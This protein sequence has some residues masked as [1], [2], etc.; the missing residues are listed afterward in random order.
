MFTHRRQA[1]YETDGQSQVVEVFGDQRA[2]D[3]RSYLDPAYR[4][5]IHRRSVTFTCIGCGK[6]VTQERFPSPTPSSCSETCRMEARRNTIRESV[7]RH[8]ATKRRDPD[9]TVVEPD[10]GDAGARQ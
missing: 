8:R 2:K 9:G 5:T 6:T 7:R 10:T 4:R 1:V 3:T